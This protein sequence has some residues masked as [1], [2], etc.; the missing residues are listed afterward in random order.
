MRGPHSVFH[1]PTEGYLGSL[2]FLA[3]AN[4][5]SLNG[6]LKFINGGRKIRVLFR[7]R[8]KLCGIQIWVLTDGA[9]LGHSHSLVD[10][11]GSFHA[12]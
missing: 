6:F 7:D 8:W 5:A 9:L 12:V 11:Y 4:S 3:I 2:Y 1:A 10:V